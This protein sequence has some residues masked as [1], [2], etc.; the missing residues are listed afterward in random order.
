M[1]RRSLPLRT[2][3]ARLRKRPLRISIRYQAVLLS[4]CF[5]LPAL[6]HVVYPLE[7]T[8]AVPGHS[9]HSKVSD[10]E[11]G[12]ADKHKHSNEPFDSFRTIDDKLTSLNRQLQTLK[13]SVEA[14]PKAPAAQN[15]SSRPWRAPTLKM[16]TSAKA[17][18][19]RSRKLQRL[20]RRRKQRFGVKSFKIL[21]ERAAALLTSLRA[22]SK[23]HALE[24]ARRGV[25]DLDGRVLSLILEYQAISGGYGGLR[26][27]SGAYACCEPKENQETGAPASACSWKCVEAPRQCRAGFLG[28]RTLRKKALTS[29]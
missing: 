26:C 1:S 29:H 3:F 15:G 28:P 21:S 8:E 19:S 4:I 10:G 5:L 20:Y 9:H 12:R 23:A 11:A 17:I 24:Q 25:S 22:I 18:L 13:N 27:R 6:C 7:S 16:Q 14:L 2:L